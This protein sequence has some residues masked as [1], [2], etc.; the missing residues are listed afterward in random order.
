MT[1]RIEKIDSFTGH[2]DCVYTLSKAQKE[3]LFYSAAGDG[4]VVEWNAD[5]PDLGRP[6]VQAKNSIYTL[7]FDDEKN[8]LWVANNFEGIH[9]IDPADKKELKSLKIGKTTFFD[10]K[11]HNGFLF[12]GDKEGVIHVIDKETLSFKKHLKASDRSVRTLAVNNSRNELAAGYSD[13]K[14]RIF[15]L[16]TYELKYTLSGHN[17]SV[18]TLAYSQ[19]EKILISGSRDAHLK[20]WYA[21]TDYDEINDVAAHLFTINDMVMLGDTDLFAT[22]SMDKSIKIWDTYSLR[23]LKVIDR[24]RHPG[25]G[26][27]INKLLWLKDSKKLLAASDDRTISMWNIF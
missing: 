20:S 25:H 2:R 6:I 7:L 8:E 15:D 10:L 24:A 5:T 16:D 3:N 27:S 14:I 18:F 1:F 19:D 12:L 13:H 17:N 4:M 21:E 26:T 9:L 22:C 11:S 23:L